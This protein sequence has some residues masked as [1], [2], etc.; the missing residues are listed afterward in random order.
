MDEK[1]RKI[2]EI[3]LIPAILYCKGYF[4]AA[5]LCFLVIV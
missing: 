4:F 1:G 2:A 5:A 3:I